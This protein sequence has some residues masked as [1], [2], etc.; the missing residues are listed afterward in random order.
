MDRI[1]SSKLGRSL[2]RLELAHLPYLWLLTFSPLAVAE[3]I[4]GTGE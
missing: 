2:Q 3:V 4:G 1:G